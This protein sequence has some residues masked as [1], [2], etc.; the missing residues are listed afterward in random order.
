MQTWIH[1][2]DDSDLR[3]ALRSLRMFFATRCSPLWQNKGGHQSCFK[4][5]QGT[6]HSNKPIKPTSIPHKKRCEPPG[7][8]HKRRFAFQL[9]RKDDHDHGTLSSLIGRRNCC[10][11]ASQP[12]RNGV[13][14]IPLGCTN[15]S[16]TPSWTAWH[17]LLH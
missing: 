4:Y 12:S 16:W 5:A 9:L 8:R 15:Y 14:Y 2:F 3:P 6:P 1:S 13:C 7:S 17:A 11:Q 10:A